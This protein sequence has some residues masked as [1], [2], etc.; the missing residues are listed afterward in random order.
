MA[1]R[2]L[3]YIKPFVLEFDRKIRLYLDNEVNSLSYISASLIDALNPDVIEQDCY[4]EVVRLEVIYKTID[5]Q[6]YS[7]IVPFQVLETEGN[8]FVLGN[9]ALSNYYY[10]NEGIFFDGGEVR[11]YARG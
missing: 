5:G 4:G 8:D 10:A 9:D 6:K 1:P 2:G 7:F 3:C 11:I